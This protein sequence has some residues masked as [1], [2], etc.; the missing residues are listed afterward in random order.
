MILITCVDD[1][2]GLLFNKRRQSQD[3]ILR[4]EILAQTSGQKLWMDAYTAA[5]FE[6]ETASIEVA[7]DFLQKAG[8]GEYALLEDREATPYLDRIEKLC[9]ITGTAPIQAIF[10]LISI[11]QRTGT[12]SLQGSLPVLPMI[13]LQKRY[14]KNEKIMN[15]AA[16]LLLSLSLIAAGCGQSK[17]A[18]SKRARPRRHLSAPKKPRQPKPHLI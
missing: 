7:E 5:L 17:E 1:A 12:A 16:S 14:T 8:L 6:G 9:S 10:S 4:K 2:G 3:R 18:A 15:L 13:R 11:S